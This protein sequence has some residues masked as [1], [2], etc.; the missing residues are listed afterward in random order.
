MG[1]L[2]DDSKLSNLELHLITEGLNLK[3]KA[4]MEEQEDHLEEKDGDIVSAI[5][6]EIQVAE[7]LRE[8]VETCRLTF[9]EE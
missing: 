9:I 5:Q 6:E 3:I 4:L 1:T 7:E 8:K 2:L